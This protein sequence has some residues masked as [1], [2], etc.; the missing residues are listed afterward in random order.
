M[1]RT[2]LLWISRKMWRRHLMVTLLVSTIGA[3]MASHPNTGYGKNFPSGPVRRQA[4][5]VSAVGKT[6][7]F[8]EFNRGQF[9]G[10]FEFLARGLGRDLRI[11]PA[12]MIL[13]VGAPDGEQE[14]G[15]RAEPRCG[16]AVAPGRYIRMKLLGGNPQASLRGVQ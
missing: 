15:G 16:N 12:E 10:G 13:E 4:P 3:S 14:G 8:F 2:T 5:V 7:L 1:T 11:A 6:P 9:D